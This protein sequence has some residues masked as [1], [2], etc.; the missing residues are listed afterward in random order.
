M[1]AAK[2]EKRIDVPAPARTRPSRSTRYKFQC[3]LGC[4]GARADVA[5]SLNWNSFFVGVLAIRALL[6]R[7]YSRAACFGN[8]TVVR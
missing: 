8:R 4:G 2:H 7:V 3:I 1:P 6:L 5:L